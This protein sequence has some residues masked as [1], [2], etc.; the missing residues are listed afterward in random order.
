MGSHNQSLT[1][2]LEEVLEASMRSHILL[3]DAHGIGHVA[4]DEAVEALLVALLHVERYLLLLFWSEGLA[5][6]QV[7]QYALYAVNTVVDDGDVLAVLIHIPFFIY[8]I[9]GLSADF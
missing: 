1:A 4:S 9:F 3:G 2:C 5:L 8:F 6:A 7:L